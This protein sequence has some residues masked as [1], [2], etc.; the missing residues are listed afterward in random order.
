M[1]ERDI[2]AVEATLLSSITLRGTPSVV[3][4]DMYSKILD[5][6]VDIG[7]GTDAEEERDDE[8]KTKDRPKSN[9]PEK[10]NKFSV[11]TFGVSKNQSLI[12]LYGHVILAPFIAKEFVI[13]NTRREYITTLNICILYIF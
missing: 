12:S 10:T 13:G 11:S 5:T 6:P 4:K 1:A 3:Y 9:T 2:P 7:E 8:S